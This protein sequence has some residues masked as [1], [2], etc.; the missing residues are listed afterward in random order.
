[1][2][3][4]NLKP[5]TERTFAPRLKASLTIEAA[6][7]LPLFL[8]FSAALIY[9][10]IIISLQSDIQLKMEEVSRELG[11]SAYILEENENLEDIAI[12]PASIQLMLL[13]GDMTERINHSRIAGG[14]LGLNA[15]QS[16]YDKETGELDII[17]SYV[18]QIPLLPDKVS[19]LLFTQRFKSRAWIGE[20]IKD[21]NVETEE[22]D[23]EYVF[24][25]PNGSVYHRSKDCPYLDLSIVSI[26]YSAADSSRNRDGK[27]YYPCGDCGKGQ[28]VSVFI[29]NFGECWHGSLNCPGLKRTVQTVKLSEAGRPPCSRCGK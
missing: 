9:F 27:K 13:S 25:T 15:L 26:P 20:D 22:E 29:T 2:V 16:T 21:K 12:N 5:H 17:V 14:A 1:M 24:I 11:K 3:Q 23:D 7:T 18:Y 8:F 28:F 10:L 4:N 19:G 6:L